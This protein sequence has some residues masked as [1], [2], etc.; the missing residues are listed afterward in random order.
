[1]NHL[2]NLQTLN[3]SGNV[4]INLFELRAVFENLTQLR[5]LSIADITNMPFD[6]FAPLKKLESLNVSGCHLGNE[7]SQMLAPLT[8]LKVINYSISYSIHI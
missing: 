7:T 3:I 2:T 4:Q 6:I 8:M 5:S 1:M